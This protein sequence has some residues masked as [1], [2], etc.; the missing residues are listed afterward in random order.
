[1]N[2]TRLA[3]YRIIRPL[4]QGGM[5]EVYLAEDTKLGRQVAIKVLPE[6]LAGDASRR[7][8]L[9]LEARAV[10][11]LNHPNIVT[12][13]SVEEADGVH[14]LTMEFV[15]GPSLAE[16]MPRHGFPVDEFLTIAI[17][18][19][20]AVGAAHQKGIVHRDLK[21]ANVMLTADGR[22]KVLDFGLAKLKEAAAA[23]AGELP[24]RE[25][26][27]EGRIVGTVSYMSP[28]QAAGK[29][30][31]H[32]SDVFSLGVVLYEMATGE[33]PFTGDTSVLVMSSVLKDTP[34]PV[35]DLNRSLPRALGRIIKIC[36]QKDP[37]RRYQSAKDVRN[38][39]ETLKEEL[40]SGELAASE[41]PPPARRRRPIVWTAIAAGA[42]VV[43]GA[44]YVLLRGSLAPA[45]VPLV[46]TSYSPL[47]SEQGLE[48]HPSISPDGKWIVYDSAASGNSDIYLR[49][50]GGQ[51]GINLT[52]N[53]P[54]ADIQP[55]FSPDGER[56]A[57]RS[58]RNGGGIFVMGKTGDAPRPLTKAGFSPAWSPD[59][60][61]IVYAT[62]LVPLP[63]ESGVLSELW[64]VT[65]ETGDTHC[66]LE[67][68][69]GV[70]P[71]WS[72]NGRFFAYWGMSGGGRRD[73]RVI[74]ARGGDPIAITDDSAVDWSPEWAPDGRSLYFVS[75]RG[76]SMNLWRIAVDPESGRPAGAPEP[77][78]TPAP[79]IS[80]LSRSAD[81]R[82]LV[83]SAVRRSSNVWKVA[84]DPVSG[85]T[86]GMPEAVTSGSRYWYSYDVSPVDQQLVLAKGLV[87]Q[88]DLF[89]YRADG[90]GMRQLTNDDKFDREPRWSPDGK[91]IAFQSN[92]HGKYEIWS[93]GPDGGSPQML[94]DAPAFSA[95]NPVWSPDGRLLFVDFSGKHALV[96]FDP[97]RPWAAQTP[98]VLP[99]AFDEP[100]NIFYAWS[101]G[102]SGVV[103]TW[104][105]GLGVYDAATK[106]YKRI[107][108][109]LVTGIASGTRLSWLDGARI[110]YV[111]AGRQNVML[112]DVS[113]G[114]TTEV[115]A[116]PHPETV[117]TPR[118][119][120]DRRTLYFLRQSIESDIY[121][122]ELGPG[123]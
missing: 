99:Q 5:G 91:Q 108:A 52:G 102:P 81:G 43:A 93:I 54:D 6:H 66:V 88:E 44:G 75:D 97:R 76:G 59:G 35:S 16:R 11:A 25:L 14:F 23:D 10:A 73:I 107:G 105:G 26:T 61:Q 1:M 84:F 101:C 72:P 118:L 39:L 57:F 119:S 121:M 120:G 94:T 85:S 83:F 8:R 17:P 41:A 46:L 30:V 58:A 103:G 123:K 100:E 34:R 24:T 78:T 53:S 38:E 15:D 122:V 13:H 82:R 113:S 36:L 71:R 27:G 67:K 65:V 40:A 92:R 2:L 18:M 33:R 95:N 68:G 4:G 60:K 21:P 56:I 12:I 104:K 98:D 42:I 96:V 111:D 116:V 51:S 22:V 19:A 37:E 112:I 20:D 80:G 32:R 28:E 79:Y 86:R 55:A 69:D 110:L 50:V 115:L 7:Q 31:D 48:N 47:T 45:A 106:T 70:D 9:A 64:T 89:L 114:R 62:R 87:E 77:V 3:H 109:R 29:P 90:T 49:S 74:P 63:S 117:S